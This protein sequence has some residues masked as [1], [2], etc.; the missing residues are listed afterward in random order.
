MLSVSLLK[1]A[2]LL[3]HGPQEYSR[4]GGGTEGSG[5]GGGTEGSG[6]GG[7]TEGSESGGGTEG[8]GSGGGTEGSG[9]GGGTE[10]SGSGGGTEGSEIGGGTEGS[11][12]GGGILVGM[13]M[14]VMGPG[15]FSSKGTWSTCSLSKAI[16]L[17]EINQVSK[18]KNCSFFEWI[19]GLPR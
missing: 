2:T 7:G 17:L 15:I 12:S 10:G 9:S 13:V 6:S 1:D 3:D 14:V 16:P 8:S 11:E 19:L 4:S 5:S 18:V